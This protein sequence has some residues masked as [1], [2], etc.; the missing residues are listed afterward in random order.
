[1]L[2][3]F[4]FAGS[5][6]TRNCPIDG[7]WV[8][9][10]ES[11]VTSFDVDRCAIPYVY[12]TVTVDGV[13]SS[14]TISLL[15]TCQIGDDQQFDCEE[16][17]YRVSKYTFSGKFTANNAAEGQLIFN[18]GSHWD[19]GDITEDMAFDWKASPSQ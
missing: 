14:G 5:G 1:M 10:E 7:K 11:G 15:D 8:T 3:L 13:Q 2:V 16:Q 6:C 17:G 12:Y 19:F 9:G 18:K 4:A